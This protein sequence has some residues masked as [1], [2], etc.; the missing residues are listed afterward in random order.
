MNVQLNEISELPDKLA[1]HRGKPIVIGLPPRVVLDRPLNILHDADIT[2]RSDNTEI[3]GEQV[4]VT[5]PGTVT[6]EGLAHFGASEWDDKRK[7][8][9]IRGHANLGAIN[10]RG[11][12]AFAKRVVYRNCT[13]LNCLDDG[14]GGTADEFVFERCL[15]GHSWMGDK[16][17]LITNTRKVSMRQCVVVNARYRA[18]VKLDNVGWADFSQCVVV[19]NWGGMEW[20]PSASGAIVGCWFAPEPMANIKPLRI[21]TGFANIMCHNNYVGGKRV[22][23][24]K[25]IGNVRC[26]N[27]DKNRVQFAGAMHDI[28]H[29][30]S[31]MF[32]GMA[33]AIIEG[34][35]AQVVNEL[36]I[37]ARRA[38][39]ENGGL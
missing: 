33:L 6:F 14:Y 35:G 27:D 10:G 32:A 15:L 16:G 24:H 9:Y 31:D 13:I 11:L 36:T 5:S 37:L 12:S 2:L 21:A 18:P 7:A 28:S 22:E 38:A 17:G 1:E 20:Q 29:I 19:G 30:R 23:W 34:A 3:F 39:R 4:S 26:A 25:V 8:N